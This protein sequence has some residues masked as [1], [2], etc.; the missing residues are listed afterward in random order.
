MKLCGYCGEQMKPGEPVTEAANLHAEC[1]FRMVGGSVAHQQR[2][3][4]CYGGDGTP[5]LR[6]DARAAFDYYRRMMTGEPERI[7]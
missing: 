6:E 2:R 1:A 7:N 4:S 3:C 5:T